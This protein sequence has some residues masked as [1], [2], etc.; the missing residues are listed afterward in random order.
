MIGILPDIPDL[1]FKYGINF[2]QC[3]ALYYP[4]IYPQIRTVAAKIH[5][6]C[7]L[8]NYLVLKMILLEI[9]PDIVH[10]ITIS[11]REAGTAHTNLHF[12]FLL[13]PMP[14][15]NNLKLKCNNIFRAFILIQTKQ[16]N[17]FADCHRLITNYC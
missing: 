9:I 7:S 12:N 3:Y 6:S 2:C 13:H 10:Y 4:V 8:E 11:P 16:P 14:D 15:E 5:A 1:L 17:H